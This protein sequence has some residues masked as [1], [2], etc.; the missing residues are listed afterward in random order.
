[1]RRRMSPRGASRAAAQLLMEEG[2]GHCGEVEQT[3]VLLVRLLQHGGQLRNVL[4]VVPFPFLGGLE[5]FTEDVHE[6]FRDGR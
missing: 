5:L 1:M 4:A 6:V 3:L 2:Q